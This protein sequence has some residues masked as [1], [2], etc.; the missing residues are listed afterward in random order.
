VALKLDRHEH[1]LSVPAEAVSRGADTQ[2]HGRNARNEVEER[3]V[4]LGLETPARVEIKPALK[5]TI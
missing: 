1:V 3:P 4:T 5:Q 2:S